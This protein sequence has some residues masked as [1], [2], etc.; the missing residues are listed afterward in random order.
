MTN[1]KKSLT[2]ID[3]SVVFTTIS[4]SSLISAY[5]REANDLALKFKNGTTYI[6]KDVD[7]KVVED[8]KNAASKGKF[9]SASIRSKFLSEQAE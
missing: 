9:F 4:G 3:K 6:Y 5:A 8:F 1:T 2:K 7:T